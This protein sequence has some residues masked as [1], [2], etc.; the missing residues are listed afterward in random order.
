MRVSPLPLFSCTLFLSA[1]L[2]FAVQ[3]MI[4]KMLL[5][6][7]GGT[8][9]GWIV[10]LAFFQVMLLAGY[11]L[12]WFFSRF[13]I[14]QN[15]L[16]YIA[17]LGIGAIF[18]PIALGK[19]D[20]PGPGEVFVLLAAAAGV[21]FIALSATSSTL[22]RMFTATDHGAAKDPYF[23]YAASNLGSFAGLFLYPLVI[24]PQF[25]ISEQSQ[26]WFYAY[27]L[28]MGFGVV[29][30]LSVKK[31]TEEKKPLPSLP[32]TWRQRGLWVALAFV[33]SSLLSGVTTHITTDV[34]SAPMVWVVPLGI[35]LLTFV[36][37]F[38]KKPLASY[39]NILKIQPVAV[40]LAIA[41]T[42]MISGAVRV[43]WYAM[44]LHVAA[45]AVVA[46]MCHMRLARSRPSA[47]GRQLAEFYLMISL[48]GALG[49]VF[50]A[51]VAPLIFNQPL[52]YP[53]VLIA[54]CLLH[55]GIRANFASRY[56]FLFMLGSFMMLI[57]MTL[58]MTHFGEESFHTV[59][60]VSILVM[61]TLHPKATIIGCTF[62]FLLNTFYYTQ[63][64]PLL[65]TR[66]FYGIVKVYDRKVEFGGMLH[67]LRF[68][69][70]GTTVHGLQIQDEGFETVMTSYYTATGPL[71]DI[72]LL[73][74]PK[75]I[76]V[77]GLGAGTIN[78][79]STPENAFTFFE[80]DPAVVDMARTRFSYLDK[81]TGSREP[82]IVVGD[83]RLELAKIEDEK[84]DL[85][86]LDAFSSDM[87]P[88]HLLTKEA[89][90]LYAD[91]LAPQ[92]MILFN[93][94]NRYFDLERVIAA[95][96]AALGLS[97]RYT[98]DT[99]VKEAYGFTSKW[100]V[101]ARPSVSLAPLWD[102]NWARL[103]LEEKDRPWS[104]D[105]TNFLSTLKF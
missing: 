10:A 21:P 97:N 25:S 33:P 28:L 15:G 14:R 68:M 92:G 87:V 84:F 53:L 57:Y 39:D 38:S 55:P 52:E 60:L 95:T 67:T 81:C 103:D 74:A 63:T 18:L 1:A 51:F 44:F 29:C 31:A 72:F 105:Y 27:V 48:G 101:L 30:L 9:A 43:S 32:S 62:I 73:Y 88:T 42:V 80:I 7:V 37:A 58:Q 2:M 4:G 45:F 8:P 16:L 79:F 93:I 64:K 102:L 56:G 83:G 23:L 12:A 59:L 54:S 24:E 82:R 91:R 71:N 20:T 36:I 104:D 50:N 96:G 40:A 26:Y 75:N 89:I 19:A 86:V 6:V 3:P 70:H 100:I 94:S 35:Y 13:S 17:A 22:Q 78:C 34:F 5:P 11:F 66:N 41:F 90:Q 77:M 76:A 85:I 99:A 61:V 46:L 65:M 98:I 47:E 69:A 49:G